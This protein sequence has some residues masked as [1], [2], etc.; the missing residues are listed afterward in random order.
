MVSCLLTE[1]V[2]LEGQLAGVDG[3]RDGTNAGDGRLEVILAALGDVHVAGDGSSGVLSLV[4]A[5][6]VLSHH[7]KIIIPDHGHIITT[8]IT[9]LAFENY[10]SGLSLF[11]LAYITSL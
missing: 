11:I 4:A 1:E 9:L 10:V 2:E 5:G 3:H 7:L 6:T 8:P